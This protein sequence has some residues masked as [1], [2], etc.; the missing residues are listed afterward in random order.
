M[1]KREINGTTGPDWGQPVQL[2]L[3]VSNVLPAWEDALQRRNS[4]HHRRFIERG[5]NTA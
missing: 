2:G 3:A 1:D 5:G 4:Q